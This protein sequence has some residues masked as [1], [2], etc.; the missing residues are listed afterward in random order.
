MVVH[1]QISKHCQKE[2]IIPTSQHGFQKG[3]STLTATISMF[4]QWQQAR[5]LL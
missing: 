3:K 1:D 5:T 4:D 2:G